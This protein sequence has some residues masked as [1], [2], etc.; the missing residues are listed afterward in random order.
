MNVFS[1]H[2][3]FERD[4][5]RMVERQ[6]AARGVRDDRVLEAMR[7]VP[8]HR[9]VPDD[10]VPQAYDDR[11]L[12]I[13]EGQTISQPYMVAIM[14][15]LLDLSPGDCVLEIGTGSGY[16]AA[17]L[18]ELVRRVLTIERMTD[19]ARSAR[20]RLEELGY[21]NV[22]VVTGDGT[23]GSP[24]NAPFDAIVVTAGGPSVPQALES[25]LALRGRLVCP[26]GDRS[27]Q[28]LL[29]ITRTPEGF[30]TQESTRC[31]F[32]PLIGAQGWLA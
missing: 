20:E 12:P 2:D 15:E 28:R 10:V 26:V 11:P 19:L 17:V 30:T 16:Q 6:I 7:R 13:G 4:R 24:E 23:L 1:K 18:A 8:R 29:K 9:F 22:T 21:D 14:T 27:L 3:P 31:V 32:V 5:R 25:Q